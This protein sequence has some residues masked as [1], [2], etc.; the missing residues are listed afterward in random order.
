M[1]IDAF[2]ALSEPNRRVLLDE[3]FAGPRT[4]NML[5]DAAGMSQPAVS[6]HLRALRDAG[7]VRVRPEGQRRWYEVEPEPLARVSAWLEPYKRLWAARLD[8]LEGHL[9]DMAARDTDGE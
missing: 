2:A 4:V 6:K 8:A 5:V 1:C 3:L 7:L 9:D